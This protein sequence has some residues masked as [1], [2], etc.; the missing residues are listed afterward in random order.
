MDSPLHQL[1][2]EGRLMRSDQSAM[3]EVG[4]RVATIN[5]MA[6]G[7]GGP[8][9]VR[10]NQRVLFR[11]LNASATQSIRLALPH[12]RFFVTALDGNPVANPAMVDVLSIG[13]S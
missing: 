2:G 13:A 9:R 7:F 3:R 5:G 6:L 1:M 12:H 10:R 11:V 8:I 4:Y